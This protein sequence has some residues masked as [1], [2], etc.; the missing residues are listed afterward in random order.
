MYNI[1]VMQ[2]MYT[3][4]TQSISSLIK[5]G[6]ALNFLLPKRFLKSLTGNKATCRI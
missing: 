4:N 5:R 3:Y 6:K 2:I 1:S